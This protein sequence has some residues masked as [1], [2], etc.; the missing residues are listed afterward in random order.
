MHHSL[1]Q[2][3]MESNLLESLGKHDHQ[4]M[5]IKQFYSGSKD[6]DDLGI[7]VWARVLSLP[8]FITLTQP[9][10]MRKPQLEP[11]RTPSL[12]YGL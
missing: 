5:Q 3:Y 7:G 6:E 2:S 1:L 12:A 10:K 11:L 9:Q 8:R 4:G